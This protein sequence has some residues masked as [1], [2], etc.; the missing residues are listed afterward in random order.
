MELQPNQL[1]SIEGDPNLVRYRYLDDG[2]TYIGL[3]LANPE[4]PQ[5]GRDENG[6]LITQEP[7]PVLG[8]LAVRQA[9]AH[10][11]DY[12]SIIENIFLGEGYRLAANVLP[13]ID[14]AYDATLEPYAYDLDQAQ[15]LLEEAGWVDGDGDGVR[16]KEGQRLELSLITNAG[17]TTRED[18]GTYI[19]DQLNSIGFSIDFQ[20]ID[21]GTMLEQM[22]AQTYDMYIIGWSNLGPD[23][24][25]EPFWSS[26]Y[27]VIGSGFNNVSYQNPELEELLTQGY[28]VPG[29]SPEDRAPIYQQIQKIIHDDIPYIFVSGRASNIAYNNRWAGVDPQPWSIYYNVHQWYVKARNP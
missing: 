24:N 28:S 18:L 5:P 6:N 19:Q 12:D 13:A 11:L 27:D 7:H 16:E 22:D 1:A 4:N 15:A 3:N 20:A 17:N 14:W 26:E 9:I 21:F 8:E 2:Y 10:A 25:D 29:C 23:P